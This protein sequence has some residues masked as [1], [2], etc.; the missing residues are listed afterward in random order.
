V[1]VFK[2]RLARAALVLISAVAAL[3]AAEIAVRIASP[4]RFRPR[5]DAPLFASRTYRLSKNKE[6]VYELKPN[7]QATANGLDF[8][9]NPSGFR[10]RRYPRDA[11]GDARIVCVGDSLTYGW[12]V[13]L[14]ATY[15]KQLER[16]MKADGFGVEVMGMGVVGYNTV[17]EYFVIRDKIPRLKPDLVLL[18]MGPND[19]ER[20]VGIKTVPETGKLVLIPYNDLIIPYMTAKTGLTNLL[21]R[22]SHLFRLA[23]LGL[24]NVK[25]KRSP[26]FIPSDVFL[27]GEDKSFQY[28]NKIKSFLDAQGIPFAVAV[29][30]YRN[31]G[32][33]PYLYAALTR[34]IRDRLGLLRIPCLD[35]YNRLNSETAKDI[36]IDG[37][38][39]NEDG[40]AIIAAELRTFI[41]PLLAKKK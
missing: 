4:L 23:N 41:E 7:T 14:R 21:M 11:G 9:V 1:T 3:A 24:F 16:L 19:F 6:L 13:P 38:H 15:H 40:Y 35:L 29:F 31:V 18:Q 25:L 8:A 37:L 33:A 36:W 2:S 30:P 27:M 26:D 20:T 5:G 28:L 34:R 12:L 22:T 32:T 17:Q 39:F 10:D